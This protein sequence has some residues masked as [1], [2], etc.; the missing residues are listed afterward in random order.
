LIDNIVNILSGNVPR[1]IISI[2]QFGDP[3]LIVK[4]LENKV[5]KIIMLIKENHKIFFSGYG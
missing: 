4:D 3:V 5:K 2:P 1:I